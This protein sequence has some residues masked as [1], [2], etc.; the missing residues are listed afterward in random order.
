MFTDAGGLAYD[1]MAS[2]AASAA[3]QGAAAA[4]LLKTSL[5]ME[6]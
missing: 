5:G 6:S 3:A 2:T 4:R 1:A